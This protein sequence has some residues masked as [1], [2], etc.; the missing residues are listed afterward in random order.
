MPLAAAPKSSTAMR[1]ATLDPGPAMAAYGPDS[2]LRTPTL[3]I[4]SEIWAWACSGVML[5][6]VTA[7]K[8]TTRHS[9]RSFDKFKIDLLPSDSGTPRKLPPQSCVTADENEPMP[10][11][12]ESAASVVIA[13]VRLIAELQA[14]GSAH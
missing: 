5:S 11:P 2:S 10:G 8:P 12:R 7:T 4:P 14:K 13:F 9:G 3:T 6:T 1:A